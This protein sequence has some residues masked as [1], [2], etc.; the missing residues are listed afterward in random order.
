MT[1]KMPTMAELRGL[2]REFTG[3]DE[4]YQG[5]FVDDNG[6]HAVIL[7]SEIDG[8]F[9]EIRTVRKRDMMRALAAALRELAKG[10]R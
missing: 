3:F 6:R 8:E 10:K 2:I 1:R 5:P 4:M 9:I 7:L